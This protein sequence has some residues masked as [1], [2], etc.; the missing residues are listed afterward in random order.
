MIMSVY[1]NEIDPFAA[2]W[3]AEPCRLTAAGEMLTGSFAGMA[4]GGQLN[5]V[6]SR[7]LMGL[8]TAWD[9]CAV[10]VTPSSHR[11]RKPS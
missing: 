9:D 3:L 11:R 8:P 1:Y 6:L 4:A 5:P 10:M 7:W 2:A